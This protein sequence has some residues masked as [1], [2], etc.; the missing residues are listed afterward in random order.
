MAIGF[1]CVSHVT[2]DHAR[3]LA[4]VGP[5]GS[6]WQP[7]SASAPQKTNRR[8]HEI[9][10]RHNSEATMLHLP[11]GFGALLACG[12]M[13]ASA[14]DMLRYV[15][16]TSPA[17]TTAEM[18]RADVEGTIAKASASAPADFPASGSTAST[19]PGSRPSLA[20]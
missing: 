18:T 9:I 5:S 7:P 6:A 19:S 8:K 1:A 17:M 4:E 11:V 2:D 13:A 20:A 12:V 10:R 15:D 3:R 16:L 14:Q